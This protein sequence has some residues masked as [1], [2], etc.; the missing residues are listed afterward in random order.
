MRG[1]VHNSVRVMRWGALRKEGRHGLFGITRHT[2][3]Y[4]RDRWDHF[5]AQRT[6]KGSLVHTINLRLSFA[7]TDKRRVRQRKFVQRC[8]LDLEYDLPFEVLRI[9]TLFP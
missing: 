8:D 1:P 6:K 5:I 7:N 2:R 9:W 4:H 3:G